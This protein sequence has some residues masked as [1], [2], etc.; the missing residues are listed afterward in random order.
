MADHPQPTQIAPGNR[1]RWWEPFVAFI[2]GNL[3]GFVAIVALAA[4]G[5]FIAARFGWRMPDASGM[6]ALARTSFALNMGVLAITNIAMLGVMWW[7]A[8]RREAKPLA[9]YFPPVEAKQIWLAIASG[10]AMAVVL[11]GLNEVLSANNI[12]VFHDTETER[13]LVPHGLGQFLSSVAVVSLIAPLSEECLFRGLLFRWLAGWRGRIFAL[14]VSAV[15]FGLLHGQFLIHPGAQGW[16]ASAELILAGAVL[17]A[18]VM[19][20]ESLRTSFATHAA[21]NLGATLFSVLLP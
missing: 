19:R 20:T 7:L 9:A 1:V 6:A 14:V 16:L 8:R 11:N 3:L 13:A 17:A 2:S 15:I 21:Y 12:I 18:W 5:A 10:L 4:A